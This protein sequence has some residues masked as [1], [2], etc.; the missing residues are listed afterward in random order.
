MTIM[1]KYEC[2]KNYLY[3]LATG[4]LQGKCSSLIWSDIT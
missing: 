3:K 1:Y 2:C 4:T